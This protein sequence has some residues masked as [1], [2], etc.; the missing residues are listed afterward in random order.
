[1]GAYEGKDNDNIIFY[2]VQNPHIARN[3]YTSITKV[4]AF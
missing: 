2:G 3:V 1:M 4:F